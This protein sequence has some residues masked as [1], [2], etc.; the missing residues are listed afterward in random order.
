MKLTDLFFSVIDLPNIPDIE[1]NSLT[2][3]SRKACPNSIFVCIRGALADGHAY[4]QNAYENGCRVFLAEKDIHLPEDAVIFTVSNTRR[5]LSLLACRFY[6]NP[7]HKMRLIGITGTKGK[8]TTA[9]LI[10]HLLNTSEIPCGYIG[11]NGISFLDFHRHSANTTPDPLTLQ[12]ALA[13]M[14]LHG[15]HTAV[16]EISSQGLAQHRVDGTVLTL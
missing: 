8:T 9:Q 14:L 4:A 2:D 7:S 6:G 1:I 15:V 16:L 10:T 12:A 3:D 5:A 13:D 11:T